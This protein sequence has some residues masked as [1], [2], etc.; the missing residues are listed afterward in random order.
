MPPQSLAIRLH[1]GL[2]YPGFPYAPS[3][4]FP[5]L[6]EI[7]T[8]QQNLVLAEVRQLFYDLGLDASH[9]GK[10]SWNPLGDYLQP[11]QKVVLKPNW[12]K[13]RNP[14]HPE[15]IDALLTHPS[16][17]RAVLEYVT[18]ALQGRGEVILA[19]A[20]LQSCN[21]D[22]LLQT[23]RIPELIELYTVRYPKLSFQI[24]DLRK[25]VLTEE[26]MSKAAHTDQISQAGD[27]SGYTLV[28]LGTH[29]LLTDLDERSERFRVTNYDHRLLH[30]HHAPGKHEYL[31]ANSLL[32][33]DLVI[34][35]PKMK[36]HVK[37]GL[38]GAL[39][40]LVGINGHKEY[41]PHH[42]NGSPAEG[43]DQYIHPSRLKQLYNRLYDAY[44][45][46]EPRSKGRQLTQQLALNAVTALTRILPKDPLLD[47]GWSG[48]DTIPRTTIDLNTI[49]LYFEVRSGN[50]A[51][52]PVRKVLNI[53]DGVVAGEGTGPLLP[54]PKL[55]GVIIG[56]SNPLQVD[57]AMAGLMGY[58]P[59][60]IR[61]LAYGLQHSRSL[62]LEKPLGDPSDLP[63]TLNGESIRLGELPNLHFNKPPHWESAAIPS[64]ASTL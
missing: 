36:T 43:G 39:K 20:P 11:G 32:Q 29:S 22:Q 52:R 7:A 63:I 45:L 24:I 37:A 57:L 27:P 51:E 59:L 55:A 56:G 62:L 30:L 26:R 53:L 18:I 8:D 23:L 48:N 50:I 21:F 33:A 60:E 17:I 38:T 3:E 58:A 6:G 5:E 2:T 4:V 42:T 16:L 1:P 9:F 46:R 47:G 64:T 12:V 44:W 49:L 10:K 35:L 14:R 19:D 41:L 15:S 25:T 61:T 31:I 34:N 40:N 54:D 13:H 28:D